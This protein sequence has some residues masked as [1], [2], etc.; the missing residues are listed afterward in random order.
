MEH[1]IFIVK[2]Y[3]EDIKECFEFEEPSNQGAEAIYNT[4]VKQ[5]G[6]RNLEIYEYNTVS[7]IY[8]FLKGVC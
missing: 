8:S 6:I 5:Q 4:L 2:G 3:D 1:S 7:K